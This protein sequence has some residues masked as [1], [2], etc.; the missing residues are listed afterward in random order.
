MFK[1]FTLYKSVQSKTLTN[2]IA[3]QWNYI[4]CLWSSVEKKI[5]SGTLQIVNCVVLRKC[6][7]KDTK[8][9]YFFFGLIATK[10]AHYRH[11]KCE[12]YY[13]PHDIK[14][15]NQNLL[16]VCTAHLQL[17]VLPTSS[18]S[19]HLQLA[20]T[21]IYTHGVFA[22]DNDVPVLMPWWKFEK[23]ILTLTVLCLADRQ[24]QNTMSQQEN[25]GIIDL[26][27]V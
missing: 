7:T 6:C 3:L 21:S 8:I 12:R 19:T 17:N 10:F 24:A 2:Y 14:Q 18:W 22:N 20:P 25:S 5:L 27:T 26:F 15:T 16:F 13:N 4:T 23:I 11:Q 1:T 9:F